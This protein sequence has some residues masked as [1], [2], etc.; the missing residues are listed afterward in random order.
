MRINDTIGLLSCVLH[1]VPATAR[2]DPQTVDT[3]DLHHPDG[4]HAMGNKSHVAWS[5]CDFDHTV[6]A[7]RPPH[8]KYTTDF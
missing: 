8:Q 3:F 7:I 5:A 1:R 2:L 4:F 6:P